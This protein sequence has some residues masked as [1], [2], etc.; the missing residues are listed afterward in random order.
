M[1]MSEHMYT[2]ELHQTGGHAYG[3]GRAKGSL[4]HVSGHSLCMLVPTSRCTAV[5]ELERTPV[6]EHE[7]T[8]E[9]TPT[10]KLLPVLLL[11]PK[12]VNDSLLEILLVIFFNSCKDVF[13]SIL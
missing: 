11:V 4:P 5:T 6:A 8:P 10:P 2:F 9:L 3:R 12:M 7:P 13:L 1:P